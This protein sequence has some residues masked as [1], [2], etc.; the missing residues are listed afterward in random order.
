MNWAMAARVR[1]HGESGCPSIDSNSFDPEHPR[2]VAIRALR[3]LRSGGVTMMMLDDCNAAVLIR[4]W[5]TEEA[6]LLAYSRNWVCNDANIPI[7]ASALRNVWLSAMA[8]AAARCAF[9][10]EPGSNDAS[11]CRGT[12][13]S[14]RY[15]GSANAR[16]FARPPTVTGSGR[17]ARYRRAS[18]FPSSQWVSP[19]ILSAPYA[20]HCNTGVSDA[21]R[22]NA[23]N[24]AFVDAFAA[25]G[26]R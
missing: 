14:M 22:A 12:A 23:S 7:T 8:V 17:S 9:S 25:S 6:S 13:L 16:Y 20:S 11:V 26:N 15:A 21:A 18:G 10:C 3:A 4:N 2:S 1:L 24:C 19:A 5:V